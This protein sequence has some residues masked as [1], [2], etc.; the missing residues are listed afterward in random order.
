MQK[1]VFGYAQIPPGRVRSRSTFIY[2][3]LVDWQKWQK[4]TKTKLHNARDVQKQ[5]GS[6]THD[7][8][9]GGKT[10]NMTQS[11]NCIKTKTGETIHL[12]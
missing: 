9:Q 4:K 6:V 5:S 7:D 11:N 1:D 3:R 10:F 12:T 2:W 8:T